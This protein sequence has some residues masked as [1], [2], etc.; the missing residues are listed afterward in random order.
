MLSF[1]LL[2]SVMFMVIFVCSG[3]NLD[4]SSF[5]LCW[6]LQWCIQRFFGHTVFIKIP[7][8][9]IL[10]RCWPSV[11]W[12]PWRLHIFHALEWFTGDKVC[13]CAWKQWKNITCNK[14]YQ[15]KETYIFFFG[16]QN[17]GAHASIPVW[18]SL[19]MHHWSFHITIWIHQ[20]FSIHKDYH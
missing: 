2:S 7:S 12:N 1:V 9:S 8:S 19:W 11:G 15:Y 3:G 6:Y 13:F 20:F 4:W 14:K 16:C 18:E 5:C 10:K 17:L